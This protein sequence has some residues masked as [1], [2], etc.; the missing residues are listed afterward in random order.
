MIQRRWPETLFAVVLSL[1]LFGAAAAC[2][3]NYTFWGLV[4]GLLA[5]SAATYAALGPASGECPLCKAMNHN[6][7]ALGL[8]DVEPCEH[9]RKYYRP[10]D[11]TEAPAD[12]ISR[13][14][15]FPVPVDK[16]L[17]SLCCLCAAPAARVK[18][19]VSHDAGRQYQG[20]IVREKITVP[21]PYY[22]QHDKNILIQKADERWVLRVR[23]Y[24]FYRSAVLK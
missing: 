6:L 24:A 1:A 15:Y 23:S 17:P 2:F 9:C 7:F 16:P 20:K 5:F 8:G 4:L 11:R 13:T 18:D 12:Y 14:P 21:I 19:V 10:A 22:A 3:H